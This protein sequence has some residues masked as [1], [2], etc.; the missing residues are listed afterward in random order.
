MSQTSVHTQDLSMPWVEKYRPKTFGNIVLNDIN[1]KICKNIVDINYF[2]NLLFYGP[3]G[4]GKTTTIINLVKSFQIK[5]SCEDKGLMIHLNA[6]DD[7]GIDII[8]NQILQFVN[9]KS[10]FSYGLKFVI[11]D[12]VDYMTKN[13]QQALRYLINMYSSNVRF[14]LICNYISRID[15]GLQTEFLKIRF[16]NL[17]KNEIT[18][19]LKQIVDAEN[20]ELSTEKIVSIQSL[21]GSDIRSMINFIQ[22]NHISNSSTI[23]IVDETV[24]NKLV[25]LVKGA[26]KR[27]TTEIMKRF[28]SVVKYL[29]STSSNYNITYK[30]IVKDFFTYLIKNE[31]IKITTEFLDFLEKLI[32][33][34][35]SNDGVFINYTLVNLDKFSNLL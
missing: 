9:S 24:W 8:R 30:N 12:E 29:H 11:L 32:H 21:F 18:M 3:P 33:T 20:I 10:L 5:N 4:T 28:D 17:P 2:P 1:K 34:N 22:C 13:A 27:K 15:Q 35:E 6:S 19:F 23:N 16:N 31:K 14:C 7:R 25:Q 26:S